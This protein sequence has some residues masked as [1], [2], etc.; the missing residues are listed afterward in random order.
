MQWRC[1]LRCLYQP[2][3]NAF[4]DG[5][6]TT[7]AETGTLPVLSI[8]AD[9]PANRLLG[10]VAVAATPLFFVAM[11]LV[12]LGRVLVS[13]TQVSWDEE[14]YFQIARGWQHGLIPY[15]DLF[16]HK[17]PMV[18]AFYLLTA[19]SGHVAIVRLL[20]TALLMCG[21]WQLFTTLRTS[22]V[23]ANSQLVFLVPALCYLLSRDAASGTNTEL[24]YTPFV[25]LS[26]AALLKQRVYA[27]AAYAAAAMAIKYTVLTDIAGLAF[28]YWILNPTR[29]DLRGSLIRWG[30]LALALTATVNGVFYVYFRMQGI[31]LISQVIAHNLAYASLGRRTLPFASDSGLRIFV[32]IAIVATFVVGL[33]CF[34]RI[35][36]SRLFIGAVVWLL[37]SLAQGCLTGMYFAHY[38][39][40]AFVPLTLVWASLELAELSIAPLLLCLNAFQGIQVAHNYAWLRD[41]ERAAAA[42]TQICGHLNSGGYIF[43]TFLAGYRVCN[44]SVSVLD[45]FMFPSFYVNPRFVTLSGSGG[46]TALLSKLQAGKLTGVV[47]T[48]ATVKKLAGPLAPPQSIVH[49]VSA[50]AADR[51][52][53]PMVLAA[54]N[55]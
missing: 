31:D 23:I 53:A 3:G 39:W 35:K 20:V 48:Q 47:A 4:N 51:V 28:V 33:P 40:P 6:F 52:W 46:M 1:H 13:D 17:P 15:R 45:K 29:P 18:Y 2:I 27:S 7:Q 50:T 22:G 44:T 54:P 24:M 34:F 8:T 19:W 55:T 10:R 37:L 14:L 26:F 16:D 25:L 38:F 11:C 5:I 12:I 49:I 30:F 41:Y 9:H 36:N 42:Y 32:E 21:A 43:T